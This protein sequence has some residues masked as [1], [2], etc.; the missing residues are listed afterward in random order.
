MVM[1]AK[2]ITKSRTKLLFGAI[3]YRENE[4]MDSKANTESLEK[5]GWQAKVDI[6]SGIR[7]IVGAEK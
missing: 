5:L 4:I 1:L 2:E 7:R 6:E 3:P